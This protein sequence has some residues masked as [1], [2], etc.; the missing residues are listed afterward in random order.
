M[1]AIAATE[2]NMVYDDHD[3]MGVIENCAIDGDQNSSHLNNASSDIVPSYTNDTNVNTSSNCI[4]EK[5]LSPFISNSSQEHDQADMSLIVPLRMRQNRSRPKKSDRVSE[6]H[7]NNSSVINVNSDVCVSQTNSK[8]CVAAKSTVVTPKNGIR[9][10]S[11][12]ENVAKA[13]NFT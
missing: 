1:E 12:P 2:V 3:S 5:T 13:V 11:V 6:G 7:E 10:R 9:S 4:Y 8:N